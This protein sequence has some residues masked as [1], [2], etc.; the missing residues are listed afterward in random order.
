MYRSILC[1]LV[2]L[3]CV[4]DS[5]S[6]QAPAPPA[7]TPKIRIKTTVRYQHGVATWGGPEV[8][9]KTTIPSIGVEEIPVQAE[10]IDQFE[11]Q[12]NLALKFQREQLASH[13]ANVKEAAKQYAV[14]H[15][16]HRAYTY[17]HVH[18]DP[19]E[20][21]HTGTVQHQ[22]EM[23]QQG[24]QCGTYDCG[25]GVPRPVYWGGTSAYY[26]CPNRGRVNIYRNS[27][28]WRRTNW[29]YRW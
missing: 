19:V 3:L 21:R 15:T 14:S 22:H 24:Q 25:C 12:L 6:A 5:V 16:S 23:P 9:D 27:Y 17:N 13:Q 2:A 20:V 7:P 8:N 28:M 26:D 11:R 1:L 29:S 4:T 10:T 18:H